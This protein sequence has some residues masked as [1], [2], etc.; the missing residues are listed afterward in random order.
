MLWQAAV[1]LNSS[2]QHCLAGKAAGGNCKNL[3]EIPVLTWTK[4]SFLKGIHHKKYIR[5][6]FSSAGMAV[7]RQL[8]E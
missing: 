1:V 4:P 5:M 6:L 7:P 3:V 8:V 2:K